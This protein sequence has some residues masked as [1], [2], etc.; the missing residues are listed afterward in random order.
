MLRKCGKLLLAPGTRNSAASYSYLTASSRQQTADLRQLQTADIRQ[1]RTASKVAWRK[2]DESVIGILPRLD[3]PGGKEDNLTANARLFTGEHDERRQEEDERGYLPP[4][5][6]LYGFSVFSLAGIFNSSEKQDT[7]EKKCKDHPSETKD[8]DLNDGERDGRKEVNTVPKS[9]F[10][11]AWPSDLEF[12]KRFTVNAAEKYDSGGGGGN[13]DD[14]GNKFSRRANFNFIAD[15]VKETAPS[16]VYIEIQD[17]GSRN[18]FTGQPFTYSNG[19]GF[20][21]GSDGLILTNAHV[22]VNKPRASIQVRLHNGETYVGTVEDVDVKS[23]LA[24]VRIKCNN[25]LPVIKLGHSKEVKPGEFVVAMGSPLSLSNTITAGVVSNVS[26]PPT[27][28]G[29][30]GRDVP[31]YI[32]TDAAITFG[33]S[34]GPLINLDG[35]AIGIN[36]M[37]VT[38]GISFAIPIDYAKEFLEKSAEAHKSGYGKKRHGKRRYAGITMVSLNPQIIDELQYRGQLHS[39]VTHG[40]LI[41]SIVVQSPAQKAGLHVGDVI[42][43]INDQAIHGSRDVYKIL[44]GQASPLKLTVWRGKQQIIMDIYPED[45]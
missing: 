42:T 5:G 44:E 26:R 38:P 13:K 9:S 7:K 43:H 35:E 19:S 41:Y 24:T 34:G 29:L 16:L 3:E 12:F 4:R 30:Q 2:G 45:H 6:L 40:I 11:S 33:N 15:V 31:E 28:M 39:S 37:K 14:G 10:K 36:S 32:Q 1:L 20:I 21:V 22:V 17:S 18:Y 27:E 23:D 25:K 8:R